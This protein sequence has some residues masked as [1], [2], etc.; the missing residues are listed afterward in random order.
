MTHSFTSTESWT[1]IDDKLGQACLFSN[2]ITIHAAAQWCGF[3]RA[4]FGLVWWEPT[5]LSMVRRLEFIVR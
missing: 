5:S 2:L 4:S 3:W 1:Y